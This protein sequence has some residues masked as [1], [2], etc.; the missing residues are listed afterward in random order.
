M[1][2]IQF[3]VLNYEKFTD[4]GFFSKVALA[5][6]NRRI[7]LNLAKCVHHNKNAIIKQYIGKF[8]LLIY[9][10]KLRLLYKQVSY[11]FFV[12]TFC[13]KSFMRY[14]NSAKIC[15]PSVFVFQ[16]VQSPLYTI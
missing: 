7:R 3:Q 4:F 2:H 10:V 14:E 5:I 1:N 16:C 11:T 15:F 9:Y 13:C 12:S 6:T 8:S